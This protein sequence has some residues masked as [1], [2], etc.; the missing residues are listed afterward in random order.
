MEQAEGVDAAEEARYGKDKRGDEL[1]AELAR[2]ESR[3]RKIREAKAALEREAREKAR[4]A[5]AA[6]QAK[7]AGAPT[8]RG[9]DGAVSPRPGASGA[10][11]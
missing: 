2:R 5:A 8:A 10:R 6:A 3:L 11:S 1:P 7:I 4:E 9:G